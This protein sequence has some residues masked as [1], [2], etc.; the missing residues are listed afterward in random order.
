MLGLQV[1]ISCLSDVWFCIHNGL[2]IPKKTLF[3]RDCPLETVE[4]GSLGPLLV[5]LQEMGSK[6]EKEWG[7]EP[8]RQWD[9]CVYSLS[10]L[11][12]QGDFAIDVAQA[13]LLVT[14]YTVAATV[15]RCEAALR[16]MWQGQ[17]FLPCVQSTDL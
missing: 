4:E 13:D 2:L 6:T 15:G 9:T 1:P 11:G 7:Q 17:R 10:P 12:R 14:A 5:W 8:Y 16:S 3:I